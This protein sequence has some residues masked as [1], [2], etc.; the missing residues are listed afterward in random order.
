MATSKTLEQP[1]SNPRTSVARVPRRSSRM[2]SSRKVSRFSV[3]AR[4]VSRISVQSANRHDTGQ[5]ERQFGSGR[6]MK[7]MNGIPSKGGP[8]RRTKD[9]IRD[10]NQSA[11]YLFSAT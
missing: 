10:T 8:L 2:T 4:N 7:R 11:T 9:H 5:D 6:I 3:H 1:K